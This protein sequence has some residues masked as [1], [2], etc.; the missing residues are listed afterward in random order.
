MKAKITLKSLLLLCAL[1]VG[2][3]NSAWADTYQQLTSIASIDESAEYV[4]GIDGTGFH[5]SGTSSWGLTALPSA[6]TPLYYSLK[7]ADDGNS[8][9]ASVT[10]DNTKYY[11]QVP[12]SNTFSMAT[13]T[14]TN[15]DLIIGTTQVSGTNYAVANKSTTT[16]HLRINGTSG[17]R[18]YAGTTGTMAFFYKRVPAFTITAVSNNTE[19]GTVALSGKVITATPAAGYT[20][21]DPA[22]SVNPANSA[23]VSQD[24]NKFTVTPSADTE[25]TINFAAIPTYTVTFS[26]G[27]SVTEETAGSGVTL[28][29]RDAIGEYA[30]AG[31]SET[32]VTTETTNAP[33]I[34]PAGTYKPTGDITLYPVYTKT[35]GG[36]GIE[37]KT[38]SVT[39]ADYAE[40]HDWSNSTKYTSVTLDENVT[41]TADGGGNT[42]KY[43]ESNNTW[44]FY[45]SDSGTATVNLSN[46]TL[47]SVMFTFTAGNSGTLNYNNSTVTS[48]TAVNIDGSSAEFTI[49]NGN[50]QISAITVNYSITDA[51]TTYYWSAPVAATVARPEIVVAE[52][53]FY[54]STTA[55]ITCDTQGAT[56][57]YSYDGETWNDYEGELT[58]TETKTIYSKAVKGSDESSVASVTATKN[59]AVPTVT[60]SGDLTVDLAGETSIEA[61]TLMATVTDAT[62]AVE[63]ATVTW[64]SNNTDVAEIG[65]NTGVVTIKATGEVTFTATFAGNSDYAEASGT[66]TITVVDSKAPGTEANPYTVAQA[67]A[68]TPSSG[69]SSEVYVSGV[70]SAFYGSGDDILDDNTHRYYISDDGSTSNQLLVYN[71]KGLNNLAFSSA[72]DVIIGDRVIIKGQ[73]T[74]YQNTKELAK[75]NYIVSLVRKPSIIANTNLLAVPSY[76]FGQT[77]APTYETLTVNGRNLTADIT[78]SLEESSSFELS[79]D[80]ENWS[81]V[82]TLAQ[83]EGSITDKEVAVRLK[84]GLAIGNY[85]GTVT[86]SST[87]ATDKTVGLSGSV[88]SATT[89]DITCVASPVAGGTLTSS[90]SSALEGATVTL[91]CT[92]AN[93]YSLTSI[94][95]TKTEDGSATNITPTASENG[96]T[97]TMPAYAVTATATLLSDNYEGIFAKYSGDLTEGD[98]ILAEGGYAMSNSLSEKKFLVSDVGISNNTIANPSRSIVWHIAPSSTSGYWTIYNAVSNRY[99]YAKASG[100]EVGFTNEIGDDYSKWSVNG[101]YDFRCKA[102]DGESTVRY[103][104]KNN[105]SV[106]FG[107]YA[108]G[109]GGPLTLYKYAELTESTITFNGNGGT[110]KN[111]ATYTQTVYDGVES[112]LN[113]NKFTRSGYAFAGWNT[114]SNGENGTA[115][116]DEGTITVTDDITLYAQ[117]S[118]LYTLTVDNNIDGGDVSVVGFIASAV[119]GTEITLT[120]SPTTG[121]AFSAWNVH[122]EGDMETKVTVSNN[123]FIMPAYNV[124]VSAT[125][126]EAFTYTLVTDANQMVSGKHY[127]IVGKNANTIKAMGDQNNNNRAAVDVTESNSIIAETTGVC[128]FVICGPDANG[129]YS[130]YDEET[131]KYL[132]AVSSSNNYLKAHE[133]NDAE[134]KWKIEIDNT[135]IAT[136][137]AQGSNTRNWMRFNSAS[138]LFSCYGSGQDNIYLY[139]KDG[140][141]PITTTASVKLN[142]YGYATFASTSALDFLD[143]EKADYSAWQITKISDTAITFSQIT[144]MVKAGTG[145]LLKGTPDATINLNLLP[146]GGNNISSTNK[147]EG[148]T[149]ARTINANEY[150]ALSGNQFVKVKA[151]NVPAG[152]ALLPA[153][154]IPSSARQL[155]IV[156]DDETTGIS[157][158]E[159]GQWIMDNVYDLQGRR[160]MKPTKGLYIV[161]GKKVVIK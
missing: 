151:G 100:T 79:A 115:Y 31:W 22:Y 140:D 58:I 147:L 82:L 156:F 126:K 64:S 18:S 56:I 6:Q 122:K 15:T 45:L 104:R 50:I 112:T 20:Y 32:N 55:E 116:D 99:V 48:G 76:V 109:N 68:N 84:A 10:I 97:F 94:V 110:Y 57:K 148:V 131:A 113:A 9:T 119:E 69:Y 152:K 98:Y 157:A 121:Y 136:V 92:V 7:K 81:N 155:T 54:F 154:A 61:G 107:N 108:T 5:Y 27:G 17:L 16:R 1:I 96:Y 73:L 47:S 86:L 134:G 24:G 38:A 95:I 37:N 74:T 88:I 142:A 46:G 44:R 25:V 124:V 19:W 59:L 4:L 33:T 144:S 141:N 11:L 66:K 41:V 78:L 49:G 145:I 85:E 101:T 2:G 160:V 60:V 143:A 93:G 91:N 75:D 14:G 83:S 87:G 123:T 53:P 34:I 114:V 65:A 72:D 39:I 130:I 63:G 77:A 43:Y 26:D 71:G 90:P 146:A 139:V 161:N 125:F 13:A 133:T 42:G 127:I 135:G 153:S 51:G 128:E 89:Y 40:E 149:E 23:T 67:L 105:N 8:F 138:T 28:P 80:K 35:E 150:Y 52:N 117:W 3:V 137:K 102:N 103:L 30:F 62:A 21:A 118:P 12:T 36:G 111:A 120:A 29:T 70:V 158:I 132:Y 129:Y 159:S 106:S